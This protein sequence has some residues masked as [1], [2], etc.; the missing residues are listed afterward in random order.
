MDLTERR[1]S[2][3]SKN[4]KNKFGNSGQS[5]M[6]KKFA[7]LHFGIKEMRRTLW[8]LLHTGSLKK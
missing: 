6:E 3:F 8:Y 2:G 4:Y 7:Y 1:Q 5:M